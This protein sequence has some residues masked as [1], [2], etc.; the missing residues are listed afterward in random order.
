[1]NL[2]YFIY[3]LLLPVERK[4]QTMCRHPAQSCVDASIFLQL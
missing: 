1:L 4:P 2:E 3:A